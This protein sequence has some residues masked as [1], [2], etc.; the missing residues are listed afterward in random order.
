M[1][2]SEGVLG[3]ITEVSVRV[4]PA[5]EARRYEGWMASDFASGCDAVRS[6]A[7]GEAL[8]DVVRLSDET[9]TRVSFGS[10]ARAACGA[11]SWGRISACAGAAGDAS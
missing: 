1:L 2:G 3:A 7:Q 10:R 8:P 5:P 11:C 9:E 4:R 6:L